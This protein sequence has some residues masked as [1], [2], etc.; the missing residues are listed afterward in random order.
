MPYH[1]FLDY[2]LDGCTE[3]TQYLKREIYRLWGKKDDKD[4]TP[5]APDIR[6]INVNGLEFLGRPIDISL[7]RADLI[8]KKDKRITNIGQDRKVEYVHIHVLNG[9][10]DTSHGHLNQPKAFY[11][12]IRRIYDTLKREC[13]SI[14]NNASCYGELIANAKQTALPPITAGQAKELVEIFKDQN[15]ALDEL[16]QGGFH[17]VFLAFEY[18]LV[19][20]K[21][22]A[23]KQDYSLLELC[24]KCKRELIQLHNGVLYFKDKVSTFF[25]LL[26]MFAAFLRNEKAIGIK[27][28]VIGIA[29]KNDVSFTVYFE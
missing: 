2:C 20:K 15:M 3:Q 9:L 16:E 26:T 4:E 17:S 25:A 7:I 21:R 6:Y 24:E 28:I 1:I 11:K 13:N 8:T 18:I 19:R 10:L 14:F 12:K 22:G 27:D 5:D 29:N 23:K